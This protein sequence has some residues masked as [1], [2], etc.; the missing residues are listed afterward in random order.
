MAISPNTNFSTGAVLTAD[1]QNRF[2]RGVMAYDQATTSMATFSSETV[3][4]TG[5]SFTAVANRYYKVTYFEPDPFS[6]TSTGYYG[7]AIRITNISGAIKNIGYNN[8]VS[9]TL[10]N[11]LG[12]VY[13][14]GTLPAGA[15]NFVGTL[16][17]NTGTM[18][19]NR[20]ASTIAFLLVE[21]I[22]PA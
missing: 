3:A 17:T 4:I 21:D 6:V 14:V 18:S 2:P 20:G 11:A 9:P 10:N 15:T 13:W 22:G 1:Q 5:S 8:F 7:M 16:G 19:S 12:S